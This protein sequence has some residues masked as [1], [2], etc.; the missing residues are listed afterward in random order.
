[1][2]LTAT[3]YFVGQLTADSEFIDVLLL[4]SNFQFRGD[5]TALTG[6]GPTDLDGIDM[7]QFPKPFAFA[8]SLN[9]DF[10]IYKLRAKA[11]GEVADGVNLVAV[12]NFNVLTNNFIWAK[13]A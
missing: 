12:A 6:G 8:I 2:P 5:I 9:D 13:C 7:S 3:S 1:M 4:T 10:A 11:A